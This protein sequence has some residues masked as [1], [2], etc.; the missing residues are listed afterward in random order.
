M[1][2][3]ATHPILLAFIFHWQGHE[4]LT[5]RK[6]TLAFTVLVALAFVLGGEFGGLNATGVALAVLASLAVCVVILLGARAQRAGATSTQVNL[7]MMVVATA[8]AGVAIV[9]LRR[10]SRSGPFLSPR[11]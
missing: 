1:L 8:V 11:D 3:Y 5:P 10:R 9:I 7:C 6:L 4:R 2:I